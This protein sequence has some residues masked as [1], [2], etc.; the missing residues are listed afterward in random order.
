VT[1]ESIGDLLDDDLLRLRETA[2]SRPSNLKA[3]P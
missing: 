1:V 3:A 2:H